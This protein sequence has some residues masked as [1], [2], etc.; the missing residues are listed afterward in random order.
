MQQDDEEVQNDKESMDVKSRYVQRR[1]ESGSIAL[2]SGDSVICPEV[3]W[4]SLP[5]ELI[6]CIADTFLATNDID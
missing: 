2:R 6:W 1:L 3:L 5:N 4:S